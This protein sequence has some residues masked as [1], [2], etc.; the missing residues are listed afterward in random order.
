MNNETPLSVDIEEFKVDS[1]FEIFD[2][3]VSDVPL[4]WVYTVDPVLAILVVTEDTSEL[5]EDI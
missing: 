2:D 3:N 5:T 1:V 4:R